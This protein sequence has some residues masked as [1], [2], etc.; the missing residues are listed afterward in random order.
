MVAKILWSGVA[1]PSAANLTPLCI[2]A[3][4]PRSRN[5]QR[6]SAPVCAPASLVISM[7]RRWR[8]GEI[9]GSLFGPH[10]NLGEH[11]LRIFSPTDEHDA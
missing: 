4:A 8:V 3:H 7:T 10:S 2:P 1:C 5:P 6:T 11:A 9:C